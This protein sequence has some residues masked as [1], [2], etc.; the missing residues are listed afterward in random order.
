MIGVVLWSDRSR[1]KAV[2]W[3]E[4]NGALA[5]LRDSIDFREA[6]WPETGDIVA[7]RPEAEGELRLAREVQQMP[8]HCDLHTR[9]APRAPG[10]PVRLTAVTG[11][12]AAR[13]RD[14][15]AEP[16]LSDCATAG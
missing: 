1:L 11:G 7:F 12:M 8:G 9:L 16:A 2:I 15:S 6:K 14:R 3:C 5:Y 10:R 13:M 4:D